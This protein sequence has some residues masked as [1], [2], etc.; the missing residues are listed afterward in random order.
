MRRAMWGAATDI[1]RVRRVNEDAVLASPPVFAVADGMGGHAAGDVASAM[2]VDVLGALADIA[3]ARLS[4]EQVLH[5]IRKADA[6]VTSA[7]VH[8]DRI[9]MGTTLCLL[10][11]VDGSPSGRCVLVAN[12]G[13][14]RAYRVGP[15]G[16]E[17]LTHDHTVT[18]ELVDRGE[19]A[20]HEAEGHPESHVVT[21]S[22]GSGARLD[23][24]WRL[25]EAGPRDVFVLATD[26]LTREVP[27]DEIA[28]IVRAS[29][30]PQHATDALVAA[31]L[32]AGGRDNVSVVVVVPDADP[33]SSPVVDPLDA[34]TDRRV[35]VLA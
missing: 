23:I 15:G 26:G 29:H 1:G 32:G 9:G 7:A 34:E 20:P 8:P 2:C 27:P 17:Q 4:R 31:A 11:F 18:Q 14:S 22:L 33:A 12:V 24:D 35:G 19:I 13:D 21:R 6:A 3:P 25:V 5:Q 10:A 16:L 30:S 28:T